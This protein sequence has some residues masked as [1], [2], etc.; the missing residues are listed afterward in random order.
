MLFV[1]HYVFLGFYIVA[2]VLQWRVPALEK[3]SNTDPF[4]RRCYVRYPYPETRDC[5]I[6]TDATW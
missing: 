3:V 1:S 4:L 2:A 5:A 6:R